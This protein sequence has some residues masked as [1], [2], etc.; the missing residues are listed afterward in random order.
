MDGKAF[1]ILVRDLEVLLQRHYGLRDDQIRCEWRYRKRGKHSRQLREIDVAIFVET[2]PRTLFVAIECR[3]RNGRQ[4]LPWI[5]QLA[6]KRRDIGADRMVAVSRDGFTECARLSAEEN[7]IEI[8]RL[9][10]RSAFT[11]GKELAD[12]RLTMLRPSVRIISFGWAH[13]GMSLQPLREALELSTEEITALSQDFEGESWLD[14]PEGKKLSLREIMLRTL[15]WDKLLAEVTVGGPPTIQSIETTLTRARYHLASEHSD[16]AFIALTSIR[17]DFE[18]HW[19]RELITPQRIMQY[20]AANE[21][22]IELHEYDGK[23]LGLDGQTIFFAPVADKR[24]ILPQ[25]E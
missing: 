20:R 15:T 3:D 14:A 5:E 24:S 4:G 6:T 22:V 21:P 18:I 1:E 19:E 8:Y 9:S 2:G 7:E 23:I 16:E 12:L 17:G 11:D 25:Q 13:C 10:E